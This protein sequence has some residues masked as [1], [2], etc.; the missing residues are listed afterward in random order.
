MQ[1]DNF[2]GGKQVRLQSVHIFET[3][4]ATIWPFVFYF[5]TEKMLYEESSKNVPETQGESK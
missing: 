5:S 2:R 1:V 3:Q 4:A